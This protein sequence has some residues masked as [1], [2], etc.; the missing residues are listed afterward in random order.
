M[1]EDY[2]N[3]SI[4][5]AREAEVERILQEKRANELVAAKKAKTK[6]TLRLL[7]IASGVIAILAILSY[8]FI[9][10]PA[11]NHKRIDSQYQR[12]VEYYNA[13]DLPNALAQFQ[14]VISYQ[15]SLEYV[16]RI[17]PR[18][19]QRI[20]ANQSISS[21]SISVFGVTNTGKVLI[22][23]SDKSY[24]SVSSWENVVA[25]GASSDSVIALTSNGT[26]LADGRNRY[27]ECNVYGWSDITQI[28]V[29]PYH[30]VGL[31]SDGRVYATG[32][33]E[34]GE[35]DVSSWS[36]VVYIAAGENNTVGIKSDG[37]L[38]LAGQG[39]SFG[40]YDSGYSLIGP[41]RFQISKWDNM[42]R[43][44]VSEYWIVGIQRDGTV[45][46]SGG[47][48]EVKLNKK[49]TSMSWAAAEKL[50]RFDK[51]YSRF[52]IKDTYDIYGI[53]PDG[54]VDNSRASMSD[55]DPYKSGN[56]MTCSITKKYRL[57]N[58]YQNVLALVA[59][60]YGEA[61]L[62]T[63]GT[64]VLSSTYVDDYPE[65]LTWKLW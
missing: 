37:S 50:P 29:S 54:F 49:A 15:D 3:N 10:V 8:F 19:C 13:G 21:S 45:L 42:I 35:C 46:V 43:V 61:A 14:Q 48:S 7:A 62:K 33:N 38:L 65:V 51:G 57:D 47:I 30:T 9:I 28:A 53:T 56:H 11:N 27:G 63:D 41:S 5:K 31:S 17:E 59:V 16:N 52:C 36:D 25:V 1:S 18:I 40:T 22:A 64:V 4:E 44:Y 26:V 55:R 23:G 2:H 32:R 58:G 12:A 6:M 60:G 20:A 34:H 24:P 39:G